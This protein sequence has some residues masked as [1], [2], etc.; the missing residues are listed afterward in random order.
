MKLINQARSAF[1]LTFLL[2]GGCASP[3]YLLLRDEATPFIAGKLVHGQGEETLLVLDTAGRHYEARG[4]SVRSSTN[5][6][7]L[8]KNYLTAGQR[9]WDRIFA[10]LDKDHADF[11][12]EVVVR[13][14]DGD[15]LACR[16]SWTETTK[17]EGVCTDSQG[18]MLP[19]HFN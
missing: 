2:L 8:R 17:P 15:E 3:S 5:L 18:R 13:A 10:G 4:F 6:A 7:A 9:H 1:L 19:V 11:V 16:V 12:A 14:R